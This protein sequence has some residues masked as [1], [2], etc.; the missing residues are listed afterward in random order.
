MGNPEE[1]AQHA[2]ALLR[3]AERSG[4]RQWQTFAMEA[5]E[6]LSSA[7]GDWQ[8]ARI[9]AEQGLAM[10][11]RE[12]NLLGCR[13]LLGYQVG[14]FDAGEDYLERLLENVRPSP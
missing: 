14:N 2:S 10:L 13:A 8:T 11:P 7:R 3:S 9:F 1:A 12:A 4:S 5:N 6:N